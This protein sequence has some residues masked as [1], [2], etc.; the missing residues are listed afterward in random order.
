MQPKKY[1]TVDIAHIIKTYTTESSSGVVLRSTGAYEMLSGH[2]AGSLPGWVVKLRVW[3]QANTPA[4]LFSL[5]SENRSHDFPS[6]L[7]INVN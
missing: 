4:R 7:E 1:F 5:Y 3:F 6:S 2:L